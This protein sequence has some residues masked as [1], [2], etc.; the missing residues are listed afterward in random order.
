MND[1]GLTEAIYLLHE[2]AVAAVKPVQT[3][4]DELRILNAL[5]FFC[6]V[7]LTQSKAQALAPIH[8]QSLE[9][10]QNMLAQRQA[11]LRPLAQSELIAQREYNRVSSSLIDRVIETGNL[12]GLDEDQ[13]QTIQA[14]RA[15][16]QARK[17]R[18]NERIARREYQTIQYS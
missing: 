17:E 12:Q 1:N 13:A 14:A 6:T 8:R 4:A 16:L 10:T 3:A 9:L 2:S 15:E 7:S 11:I 5:S 18:M